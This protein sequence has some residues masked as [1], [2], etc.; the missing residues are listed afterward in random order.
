MINKEAREVLQEQ[1]DKYGKVAS[2]RGIEALEFVIKA[3][4]EDAMNRMELIKIFEE[5]P[6]IPQPKTEWIPVSS[7]RLPEDKAI[8]FVTF[9]NGVV[10]ISSWQESTKENNGFDSF[11]YGIKKDS[12]ETFGVVAWMPLPKPLPYKAEEV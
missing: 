2:A 11:M 5:P 1:I 12:Y 3:L 10:G 7:E 9:A 4:E 6:V 8:V